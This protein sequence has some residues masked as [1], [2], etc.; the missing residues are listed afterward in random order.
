MTTYRSGFSSPNARTTHVVAVRDDFTGEFPPL[1][2][3]VCG[4]PVK[5]GRMVLRE[6]SFVCMKCRKAAGW[7]MVT[8]FVSHGIKF[9][10]NWVTKAQTS[11]RIEN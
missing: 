4:Q 7:P 11:E 2:R 8:S 5:V 10:D 1:V 3:A 9:T 6:S